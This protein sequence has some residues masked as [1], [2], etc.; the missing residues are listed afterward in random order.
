MC[1]MFGL[2]GLNRRDKIIECVEYLKAG[3][4]DEQNLR[5]LRNGFLGHTRLSINGIF[6]GSQPYSLD[7]R[8]CI[9]VGEIYNHKELS[10][11]YGITRFE[12]D[13]DG[14]VILPLFSRLG[15]TFVDKLEGMFSIAIVDTRLGDRLYVYTDCVA[16]K[17]VYYKQCS[18]CFSFASEI[19]AL[20]DLEDSDRSVPASTFDRY[21]ALR[22]RAVLR[23]RDRIVFRARTIRR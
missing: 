15:P 6:N 7:G 18:G 14:S 5:F 12:G 3:G 23:L 10:A 16:V 22:Y 13:S 20:P 1:R 21:G 2:F 17:P 19:E 8:H 11:T 4:P 9:F